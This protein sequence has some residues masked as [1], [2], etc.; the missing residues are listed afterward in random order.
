MKITP[1]YREQNRRLHAEGRYGM[2]GGR[3]AQPVLA[4]CQQ[5]GTRDVLDY[6]CGQRTLEASLGFPIHNYDPC[7]PELDAPPEPADI[8]VCTDVLEHVEPE[9]LEE[10]LDDLRRVTRD[11]GIF[12]IAT[13]AADKTL[14]DGR[15]AHLIQ[16]PQSWWMP[17]LERRFRVTQVREMPGEF[18][19]MVRALPRS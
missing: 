12:L 11:A 5:L 15:N 7:I 3:W 18:A 8:V 16:Q 4:L 6:G 2:S 19:V 10:V 9:C 13:R 14:P 1:E 17:K